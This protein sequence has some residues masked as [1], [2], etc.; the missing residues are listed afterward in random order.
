MTLVQYPSS[1]SYPIG[2]SES[3]VPV[4]ADVLRVVDFPHAGSRAVPVPNGDLHN[5]ITRAFERGSFNIQPGQRT[6]VMSTR[7]GSRRGSMQVSRTD[8]N[9]ALV[10]RVLVR[11]NL[12]DPYDTLTEIRAFVDLVDQLA[13]GRFIEWRPAGQD[14]RYLEVT[15][16]ATWTPT[17][18]WLQLVG[19][20]SILIEISFPIARGLSFAANGPTSTAS[21]DAMR[22]SN[23]S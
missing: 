18:N 15:G 9:A 10:A 1:G 21:I 22:A 16:D 2:Y 12:A 13:R 23:S 4:N 11:G 20:A 8:D 14:P 3:A 5:L 6:P 19:G 7:G 17:Y